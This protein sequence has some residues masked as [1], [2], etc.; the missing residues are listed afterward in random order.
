VSAFAAGS[1]YIDEAADGLST[2]NVFVSPEVSGSAQLR[3][4]LSQQVSG[5]AIAVAV[6][7]KN[8][9][10]EADSTVDIVQALREAHPEYG[11]I[12]VAVGNDLAAGSSTIPGDQA[13]RI[14]NESESAGSQGA[15]LSQ[16]IIG[17]Q[18]AGDHNVDIAPGGSGGD[19]VLTIVLVVAAAV[20][21]VAG[22][23]TGLLAA[24]RRRARASSVLPD[25]VR[26]HLDA[27]AVARSAYERAGAAG[28]AAAGRTAQDIGALTANVAELFR[29]L[30]SR[31]DEGQRKI[32]AVE[33]DD[34]LRRL[35]GAL[36]PDYLL[37]I[38]TRP[39]LWDDPTER[40]REV[41]AAVAAVSQELLENIR[42]VN[43]QRALHFQVSLDGLM[44]RRK[45][46][47]EWDRAFGDASPGD[48]PAR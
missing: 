9:L 17:I 3:A 48:S 5:D 20:V 27:L 31:S 16:A 30:R 29:R 45:E 35:S 7:S 37:D 43:A 32:A 18:T 42:Q 2:T 11:T 24:A 13:L 41:E 39:D 6:L 10:L 14:A 34:K 38:Q 25:P 44:G 15:S 33:Y 22:V 28:N 26:A 21:V 40:A 8:A 47:Q 23:M 12:I 4:Q 36:Q 46:L 19:P 1:G